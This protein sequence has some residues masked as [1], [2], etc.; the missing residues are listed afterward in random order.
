M[1]AVK[2]QENC[3]YC[4]VLTLVEVEEEDDGSHSWAVQEAG[5]AGPGWPTL[6]LNKGGK[7]KMF[8]LTLPSEVKCPLPTCGAG[9]VRLLLLGPR[10]AGQ[11]HGAQRGHHG[12]DAHA[13]LRRRGHAPCHAHAG[14]GHTLACK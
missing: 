6:L 2:E 14:A 11:R 3:S 1:V 7:V 13:R 4:A 12:E 10:G 9:W 8:G 5:A